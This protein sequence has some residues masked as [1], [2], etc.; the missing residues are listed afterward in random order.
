M[1]REDPKAKSAAIER[2]ARWIANLDSPNAIPPD[3]PLDITSSARAAEALDDIA[4]GGAAPV[5][6]QQVRSML[7]EYVDLG[8][9]A[10]E[11][12]PAIKEHLG[13]CEQCAADLGIILRVRED[14][15]SWRDLAS[16]VGKPGLR[17][18]LVGGIWRW[19]SAAGRRTVAVN[20]E[21]ST[22]GKRVGS[23][24][25]LPRPEGALAFQETPQTLQAL[26]L[27]A[28]ITEARCRLE[29]HVMPEF[30]PTVHSVVWRIRIQ[31]ERGAGIQSVRVGLGND[32]RATKGWRT[33]APDRPIEFQIEDPC[34]KSH[35]LHL[36]WSDP[37]GGIGNKRLEIPLGSA[38]EDTL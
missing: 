17:V 26:A 11:R 32:Q 29:L 21:D 37:L 9:Q 13:R 31:M 36:E 18:V 38:P 5:E 24:R 4:P 1:N 19:V 2:L 6:C 28:D 27:G 20:R 8:E 16:A 7:P 22:L 30:L 34:D 10:E 15:D 14:V 35:W 23:W 3:L 33:L 25:M 12:M